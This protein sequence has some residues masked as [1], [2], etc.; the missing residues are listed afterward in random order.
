M[1]KIP[2]RKISIYEKDVPKF[3]VK[4]HVPG[5][6]DPEVVAYHKPGYEGV[7]KHPWLYPPNKVSPT[8]REEAFGNAVIKGMGKI[9]ATTTVVMPKGQNKQRITDV[10]STQRWHGVNLEALIKAKNAGVSVEEPVA[11]VKKK[12]ARDLVIF[13][14]IKGV[15][16]N[17]FLLEE[18]SPVK[19]AN[20]LAKIVKQLSLLH[21]VGLVHGDAHAGNFIVSKGGKVHILDLRPTEKSSPYDDFQMV[22]DDVILAGAKDL[23]PTDENGK[24]L[25][26]ETGVPSNPAKKIEWGI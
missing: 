5:V 6:T 10:H 20:V 1:I 15:T 9:F 8:E 2:P 22:Y 17:T 11:V 3:W 7:L 12:G 25:A 16:L 14:A 19:K 18:K 13:K 26:I 23:W 21:G 4:M 24:K